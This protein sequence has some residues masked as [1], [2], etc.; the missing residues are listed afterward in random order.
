MTKGL[1][2][3]GEIPMTHLA[4]PPPARIEAVDAN[5][6]PCSGKKLTRQRR[7]NEEK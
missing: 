5:W 6:P 3:L 2:S 7:K 4:F 1:V